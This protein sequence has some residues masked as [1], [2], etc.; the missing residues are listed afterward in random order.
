MSNDRYNDS[1]VSV[2]ETGALY[3]PIV[4]ICYIS[5]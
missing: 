3:L 4:T 2:N 1:I 5:M